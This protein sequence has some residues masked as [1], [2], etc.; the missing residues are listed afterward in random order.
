MSFRALACCFSVVALI[1]CTRTA[2]YGSNG[3]QGQQ[4]QDGPPTCSLDRR[5]VMQCQRG[6]WV[7]V[8]ACPGQQGCTLFNGQIQCDPGQQQAQQPQG[9][10]PN[11]PIQANGL[12]QPCAAEGG[13]ECTPD[14][15]G[16]TLCRGGRT[17][18]AS[19]CR[20]VRGCLI[21]GAGVDCDHSVALVGDPCESPKEIACGQDGHQFLR[22]VNGTYQFTENCRSACL[23]TSGRVLCQ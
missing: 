16:L 15:R 13:Y 6:Q 23:S 14:K 2:Q 19:T 20:G 12:G 7:P 1:A 4:C 17:T 8:Q 5:G 11:T 10:A 18:M 21:T 9:P 22:C 3:Q